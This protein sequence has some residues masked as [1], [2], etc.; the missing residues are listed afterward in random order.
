M[1]TID[2]L[3]GIAL[4]TGLALSL[5]LWWWLFVEPIVLACKRLAGRESPSRIQQG[6]VFS[7][8][9]MQDAS[10]EVESHRPPVISSR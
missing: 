6:T 3:L 1:Q 9:E 5:P 4:A 8:P 7:V 10:A 2:I